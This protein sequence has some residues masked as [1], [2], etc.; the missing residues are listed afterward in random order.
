MYHLVNENRAICSLASFN[1]SVP[2]VIN[3]SCCISCSSS[4]SNPLNNVGIPF[5]SPRP[6]INSLSLCLLN[7]GP[8]VYLN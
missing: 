3:A 8:K 5:V 2:S 6:T 4:I 7:T 1:D